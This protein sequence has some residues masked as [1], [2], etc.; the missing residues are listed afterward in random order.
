MKH[1]IIGGRIGQVAPRFTPK[2]AFLDAIARR[3]VKNRLCD[4]AHG[5]ITLIDGDVASNLK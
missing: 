2:P 3:L 5:Q 1:T 4:L